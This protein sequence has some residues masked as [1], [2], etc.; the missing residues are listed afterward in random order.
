VNSPGQLYDALFS[1][2]SRFRGGAYPIHKRLRFDD[3]KTDDIYD[4]I[5]RNSDVPRKGV[6]L[7][8]GCGVGFGT[9]RLA[10]HSNAVVLGISVSDEEIRQASKNITEA[11]YDD[12]VTIVHKSYDNLD[13][14]A[15][16]MVVA[17]ESLKHSFDVK[18]SIQSIVH[19][20]KPGGR[21]VIVEDLFCGPEQHPSARQMADDWALTQ[22]LS[23]SDYLNA[24]GAGRTVITD[25]TSC[26]KVSGRIAISASLVAVQT[27]LTIGPRKHAQAV[28]AFRGGLHLQRLYAEGLMHYKSIEFTKSAA[29][30][31]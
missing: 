30:K 9:L 19:A 24:L 8:A 22:I 20:L 28:Q 10:A 18:R 16:E 12:R 25:L 7:D 13:K 2:E 27:L 15:F 11:G 31:D 1:L 21:M 3:E 4:W 17:V 29:T 5:I 26:A 14:D 6:I 23:E